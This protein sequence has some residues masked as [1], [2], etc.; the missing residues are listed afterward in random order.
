MERGIKMVT[1]AILLGV[2]LYFLM[3][4]LLRQS[5]RKAEDRS[6]LIAALVLAYMVLFGHGAPRYVNSNIM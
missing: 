3:V 1:H 6:I 2:I 4:Y 5:P